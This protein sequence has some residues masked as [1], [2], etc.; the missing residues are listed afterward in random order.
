MSV[1]S[2]LCFV[3]V[4]SYTVL[5]FLAI[6]APG[7]LHTLLSALSPQGSGPAATLPKLGPM[8]PIYF[9][10]MAAFV[11]LL[12]YGMWTLRNWARLVISIITAVSLVFII[13]SL[14]PILKHLNPATFLLSLLR[15]ALCLLVLWYLWTPGVRAAFRSRRVPKNCESISKEMKQ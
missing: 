9:F 1:M 4:G 8:L 14:V 6:A 2:V 15:I 5:L 11:A 13:V 12:G 3:S 10:V 7:T